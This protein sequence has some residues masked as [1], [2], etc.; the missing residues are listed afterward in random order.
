MKNGWK[1]VLKWH[2]DEEMCIFY[3]WSGWDIGLTSCFYFTSFG[4]G[5][6]GDLLKKETKHAPS[7]IIWIKIIRKL[8]III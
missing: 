5:P 6:K 7:P 8:R 1:S 2:K 4:H 3:I